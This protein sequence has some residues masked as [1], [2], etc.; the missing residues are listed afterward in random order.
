MSG[1]SETVMLNREVYHTGNGSY[2]G[3]L[4]QMVSIDSRKKEAFGM[5]RR[6]QDASWKITS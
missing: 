2:C 1:N 4:M 3:E 5:F 6:Q